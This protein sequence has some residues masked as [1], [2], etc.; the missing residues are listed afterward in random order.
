MKIL[1]V[2]NGGREHALLWKL[3]R[4]A[5]EA[6]FHITRGNAGTGALAE[7]IALGPTEIA[8]LADWTAANG[9]DLTVVGPEVPLAEGIVDRFAERGLPIFGPTAAAAEIESSKA[10]S[11]RLMQRHGIPTAAFETF[12]D[13]AGAEAFARRLG[14]PLVV[15]ASGLAAGKGA[16]V[17]ETMDEALGAIRGILAEGSLGEAG[18]ELVIEEFMRGEEISLFALT[19]GE[20]VVPLLPAQDHKRIGEGDTGPNTGGMGAYAPVAIATPDVV[21]RATREI[22]VPTVRAMAAEGRPFRGL[23]YAGLMLTVEG[24]KVVE[25]NCRFG[26]PETQVVLPMMESSLLE[27]M[28]AIARGAGLERW[29][30]SGLQWREGAA[31]TTVLAAEG[32]PG[33]Y[34]RGLPIEIAPEV[35]AADDVLVFHAGTALL[36]GMDVTSGGRVLAVTGLGADVAEAAERSR[37]GAERIRFPGRYFR[38]DIAWREVGRQSSVVGGR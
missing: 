34:R 7:P 28:L 11:K 26:D 33:D 32:Y 24:P 19:D 15:K 29:V 14:A 3:H 8:A 18:S 23:L 20:C 12:T 17:C 13:A 27:P 37:W 9:V 2:G 31:V 25:F 22:L 38:R 36:G 21:E 6:E 5:P 4:D 1:I 35:S 10:F 16:V 30:A